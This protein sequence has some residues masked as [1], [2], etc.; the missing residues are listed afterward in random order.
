LEMNA[1]G[2]HARIEHAERHVA[3]L[4]GPDAAP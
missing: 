4:R 1:D 2:V 3:G